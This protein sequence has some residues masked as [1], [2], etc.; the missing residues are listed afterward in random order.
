MSGKGKEMRAER[1]LL[2]TW[3]LMV[4]T[5][6][7]IRMSGDIFIPSIS[8][9]ATDMGISEAQATSN[10][11]YYYLWLMCSYILFG[12]LCDCVSKKKML[13]FSAFFCLAGCML[14]A[15]APNLLVLNIGRSLQALATGAVLLTSQ[16]WIGSFSDKD[17]MLGRLAWFSLITTLSPVL[18]PSIGGFITDTLS[19]RYDFWLIALLCVLIIPAVGLSKI[20]GDTQESHIGH[21]GS[22][23]RQTLTGYWQVLS[24]SPIE[25]FSLTAQ[26]LFLAQGTFSAINSF[27]FV[28]EFGVSAT[29]LGML[30]IPVVGGLVI[31]RFPTLW[32]RKHYGVRLT[33]IVNTAIVLLSAAALIAY[34]F[35]T[36]SHNAVEV[37]SALTIQA[38]GFSGLAILS[39]NNSMLVAGNNKG[40]VSGFYNFMNQGASLMGILVAQML[41]STGMHATDILQCSAYLLIATTLLGAWLFLRMYPIYQETLD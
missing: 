13:L 24:H 38:M 36:G 30:I 23:I 41:F 6:L 40:V 19:W 16:V 3:L 22:H 25:H 14:C 20:V 33:F 7:V 1:T 9:M 15:L 8:H 12:R 26:G 32:L 5:T 34:Y 18:A 37:I 17:N 28:Q 10:L 29:V 31:G 27:L 4:V 2:M 39:L 35:I 21:I 11:T